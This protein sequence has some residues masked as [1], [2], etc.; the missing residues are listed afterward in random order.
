MTDSDKQRRWCFTLQVCEGDNV[1]A[2]DI[3]QEYVEHFD[4]SIHH[5]KCGVCQVEIA[6]ETR[7]VHIQG[8]IEFDAPVRLNHV[9]TY[10]G[11]AKPHLEPARGNW[12]QNLEYCTKADTRH[13]GLINPL[14]MPDE[15][16]WTK[17]HQQQGRRNDLEDAVE[18]LRTGKRLAAVAD[19]HPTTFVKY[20]KGFAALASKLNVARGPGYRP[21]DVRFYWGPTNT[22]KSSDVFAEFQFDS[23]FVKECTHKWW[24]GYEGQQVVLFDDFDGVSSD[25]TK[26]LPITEMLRILDRYPHMVETKGGMVSMCAATTTFI[27]TTNRSFDMLYPFATDGHKAALKRRI[28]EFVEFPNAAS[29]ERMNNYPDSE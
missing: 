5:F 23:I 4:T 7:R 15:E 14:F 1:Y 24:D 25:S 11:G 9:K 3:A 20:H 13:P 18:T 28:Y 2:L 6:P 10:F 12:M 27:I 8:Y 17:F 22:G 29:L 26:A 21:L 16:T 19:Q